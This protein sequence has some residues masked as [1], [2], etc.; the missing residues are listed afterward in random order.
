MNKS[1]F[2]KDYREN[3]RKYKILMR[4][5]P[6]Q[7]EKERKRIS[8]Y[9]L[10][11]PCAGP[12]MAERE[13]RELPA[14]KRKKIRSFQRQLHHGIQ[15]EKREFNADDCYIE[16]I[17]SKVDEKAR[18]RLVR[19]ILPASFGFW[20]PD[21]FIGNITREK[22]E[23]LRSKLFGG[24][25]TYRIT[26]EDMKTIQDKFQIVRKPGIHWRIL[27]EEISKGD[28]W[29]GALAARVILQSLGI[30]FVFSCEDLILTKKKILTDFNLPGFKLMQVNEN[31]AE[32]SVLKL[33]W[34]N[35]HLDCGISR[36]GIQFFSREVK[37]LVR[38]MTGLGP[39][40]MIQVMN[41]IIDT[42]SI[43]LRLMNSLTDLLEMERI[44][45]TNSY[46]FLFRL[47][48][49]KGKQWIMK[50]YSVQL[51]NHTYLLKD[52]NSGEALHRL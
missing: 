30:S 35:H 7:N 12:M 3:F 8:R 27:S 14:K 38:S 24:F 47:H 48:S 20:E 44:I 42:V 9:L 11:T 46:H 37:I 29:A 19:K 2:L 45:F 50:R 36:H 49:K 43:E 17:L 31:L 39:K 18:I 34:R 1:S 28:L 26:I 33:R 41:Y 25:F 40:V 16:S 23:F 22:L 4:I 10:L 52:P 13:I 51:K 32:T 15:F 21:L 6:D 5:L